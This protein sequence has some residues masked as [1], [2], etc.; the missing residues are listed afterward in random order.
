[1]PVTECYEYEG[2]NVEQLAAI[3]LEK[4]INLSIISPRK[5]PVL[6]EIF[7][8]SGGELALTTSKNY[9]KDPR[10]LVLLKGFSLKERPASPNVNQQTPVAQMP[11]TQQNAPNPQQPAAGIQM[12][13]SEQQ[14]MNINNAGLRPQGPALR[15]N[16][17]MQGQNVA[18]GNP[19]PPF[20]G[21][22]AMG[23]FPQRPANPQQQQQ[24]QQQQQPQPNQRWITPNQNRPP[25]MAAQGN[26]QASNMM[27][28]NMPQNNMIPQNQQNPNQPQQNSALISQ[29]TQPSNISSMTPQ[30]QQMA[31]MAAM[32][33]Q[34]Q[35]Q[36]MLSQQQVN[37]NMNLAPNLPMQTNPQ[38]MQ[39]GNQQ[40]N[41][42][43]VGVQ[44]M[45]QQNQQPVPQQGVQMSKE[46]KEKILCLFLIQFSF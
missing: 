36:Q 13:N 16:T 32:Q 41:V 5:I 20:A 22:P 21:G 1:M 12:P 31:R 42:Q 10:H 9:S 18:M 37:P 2:K 30:Q 29:L 11:P 27:P 43:G 8:K 17:P 14:N 34:Q 40:Q 6:F 15:P 26:M 3:F 24:Q 46:G 4:N 28:G 7:E 39:Q 44:G 35:N 23:N 45:V 25:F 38:M 33:N 19:P